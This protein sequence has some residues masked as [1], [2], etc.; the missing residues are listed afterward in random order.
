[1]PIALQGNRIDPRPP[2]PNPTEIAPGL[3][4]P[5]TGP[6]TPEHIRQLND[7]RKRAKKIRRAAGVAA[8][9]G[10]TMAFFAACTFVSAA[11]GDLVSLILAILLSAIAFNELRGG[12]MVRRMD[13][14][15]AGRLAVNQL[16]LGVVIVAYA[17]WSL[18]S[19]LHDPALKQL[20]GQTGDAQTDAMLT[21][22]SMAVTWGLYGGLAIVGIIA[23]GLT[24]WYY[25]SRGA[26]I[27]RFINETP[28]WVVEAMRA[29]G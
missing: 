15:G 12:T 5:M 6:L 24:A 8:A 19:T 11:F 23:P 16:A 1:M 22:L 17:V 21:R 25:A 3:A 29:T 4:P 9:S 14:R 18:Y 28:A 20:T 27:R 10:W 7:G 2:I 26:L 13:A